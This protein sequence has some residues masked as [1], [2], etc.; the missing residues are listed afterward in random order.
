MIC[1]AKTRRL[2]GGFLLV[3]GCVALPAQAMML[4][5]ALNLAV[6]H[7]P[8]IPLSIAQYE[9]ELE[10]GDQVS[11]QLWPTVSADGGYTWTNT[12][13]K[14]QFFGNFEE[15]YTGY[16]AGIS[17]RQPLLRFDWGDLRDQ[18]KALTEQAEVGLVDRKGRFYIRIAERYFDVLIAQDELELA[19]AEATAIGESLADTQ[20]RHEVG[21]V[22][23]TDLKEAQARDDLARA[24]LILARQKLS[25][26]QDAL[27]ESTRNG[28]AQLPALPADVVLPA[29]QPADIQA[30]VAKVKNR[31]PAVLAAQQAVIIAESEAGTAS[32][33]LLPSV[34]AVASYRREDTSD[35]RVGSERNDARVGVELTVPLYQGGITRARSREAAARM[36]VAQSDRDRIL[37]EAERQVRQQYR[38]LE[39]AYAQE[40]ALKLAVTSALAAEEATRNG[41][42]AGTRTITDVLNARSAVISAQRDYSRTRYQLLLNRMRLK[43]LTAE[44]EETDFKLID[45]LLSQ[46]ATADQSE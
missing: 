39:A 2:T 43:Q 21:L 34:D 25:T 24:K 16:S 28:Y 30:W 15:D 29:L 1:L 4:T 40:K 20:K 33:A 6:K 41:Y 23:G 8:A 19:K 9:A 31:N 5:E 42:Q 13:S 12:D 46:V 38:E 11:G 10:L 17:A 37:L 18:S 35:S 14:S 22:P 7:D 44:L 36:R 27:E 26:A 45:G 32:S 3:A